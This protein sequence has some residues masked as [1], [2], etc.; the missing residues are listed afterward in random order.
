MAVDQ[1]ICRLDLD[2]WVHLHHA[3]TICVL[4]FLSIL[5]SNS[6]VPGLYNHVAKDTFK[7]PTYLDGGQ[8]WS[9]YRDV[10]EYLDSCRGRATKPA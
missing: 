10:A 6:G 9:D 3:R 1:I 5:C 7:I 4:A 8:R 2:H